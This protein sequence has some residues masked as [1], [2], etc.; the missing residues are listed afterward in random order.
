MSIKEG[1]IL[2]Y[3]IGE[4]V[5]YTPPVPKKKDILFHDLPKADQYWRRQ[6]DFPAIFYK[7]HREGEGIE[8]DAEHT[9]YDDNGALTHLSKEDTILLFGDPRNITQEYPKGEPEG[10]QLREYRRCAEGVWMMNNGEITYLTGDHY[11]ALQW[12]PM[13]GCDNEV[14]P[15]SNYGQYLQ[16]QRDTYYLWEITESH[17]PRVNPSGAVGDL[18][19]KSK[20][21]GI[22]QIMA[23]KMLNRARQVRQKTLRMMS[24][25]ESICKEINFR[26]IT[27]AMAGIPAILLPSRSKQNE[28][29]VIFGPPNASRN[30]LKKGRRTDIDYLDNWLCTVPTTR[31]GF[32]GV[33]N[34]LAWID[35]WPK[36][37]DSTYPEELLTATIAA[38]KEGMKR[39]GTIHATSYVPE[40][41]D[42][43]FYESR[44]LYKES[45]LSTRA[46]N[47]Y[48]EAIGKTKSELI[49]HTL[50][51]DEGI[52]GCCDKYGKPD[53]QKIYDFITSETE[54]FKNDPVRLQ[55]FKRQYPHNENDPWQE[56]NSGDSLFD[57]LRIG[58]KRIELEEAHAMGNPPYTDF[59]LEYETRPIKK[60]LG[61]Q[62]DFPGKI[63]MNPVTAAEK[64]G[65]AAHGKFK[66]YR[67]EWMPL[68]F[69]EKHVNKRVRNQKTGLL[70]PDYNSPFFI[71]IDPTN[72]RQ[73][74]LT[75]EGSKNAIQAFILPTPELDSFIGDRVT[76]K[77]L[78]FEYLYREDKPSDTLD[79]MIKII[80]Y[81]NCMVQIECNMPT[82]AENMIEMGLGHFLLMLNEETGVL[83][84]WKPTGKQKFFTSQ[85]DTVG[86][87]VTAGKEHLGEPTMP[88]QIDNIKYLDSLQV[89][90]QLAPFTMEDTKEFD[91][92]VAYLEGIM[93]INAWMGWKRSENE[94][95]NRK[96]D[97]GIKQAVMGLGR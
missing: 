52:F 48:G 29:E 92:A 22:T 59:N 14:E 47:E 24:I 73:K 80:L 43:S 7:W 55:A 23:L 33:T 86:W 69:M 54:K 15:G 26:F 25:T 37:K 13:L 71:S 17:D 10:L 67:P 87:Y 36:I 46:Q 50:T 82:W 70:M 60:P 72:Y 12:Q 42:R 84:P 5:Y 9:R 44:K 78:F 61:T 63:L 4:H 39:K 88:H 74:K 1:D 11:S 16:F 89:L 19:V 65:G 20:K 90:E 18:L 91:A 93:G 85:Q 6:K 81:L 79:D 76:E 66:W 68:W 83:E 95:Q 56:S 28:G 75:R 38:V 35:E 27:Y 96:K 40:K 31:A 21:T 97:G 53:K 30:P 77:R 94:K 41:S 51:V 49:C 8:T 57:L 62:Y 64:R 34:F 58:T 32:D 3:N 45:K 2:S